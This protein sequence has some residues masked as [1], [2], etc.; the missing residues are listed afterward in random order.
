[1]TYNVT[2]SLGMILFDLALLIHMRFNH[3]SI[4]L[5]HK[6]MRRALVFLV[7]SCLVDVVAGILSTDNG[8]T[9]AD[10]TAML[11]TS[12]VLL[13]THFFAACMVAGYL[14]TFVSHMRMMR[15]AEDTQVFTR[16]QKWLVFLALP[17][18][19]AAVL[20]EICM[21]GAVLTVSCYLSVLTYAFFFLT[22]FPMHDRLRQRLSDLED[23]LVRAQEA[24]AKAAEEDH[25]KNEFLTNM[26]HEIRTP[27]NAIL[28]MDEM[29][30]RTE[31][32]ERVLSYAADIRNAGHS[33]L[34]IINDILDFSR[35]ESGSLE[36]IEAPYHLGYVLDTVRSMMELRA[37]DKGLLLMSEID[38]A[39]PDELTGDAQRLQ[40]V[41]VN[42]LNNA[43]KYTREGRVTLRL[44]A[45]ERTEKNVTLRFDIE[46]TGIGIKE[47]DLP[48]LFQSYERL[49]AE[50]NRGVEGTGLG[51]TITHNLV[52]LMGGE[53]DVKSEYGRGSV[54]SVTL[55]QE[56]TGTQTLA[57]YA[58]T[59]H[60]E[61]AGESRRF[62]APEA[63]V[64]AVDDTQSNLRVVEHLLRQTMI[65]VDT[66]LSG[67]A[68]LS[69]LHSRAYD[70]VLLDHMMPG[71][72]GIETLHKIRATE[73]FDAEKT[74]ILVLTANAIAGARE[75]YLA[76]GFDDYLSKPVESIQLEDA[77]I[78]YLPKEKL[79]TD[80]DARYTDLLAA[81]QQE[82]AMQEL[83]GDTKDAADMEVLRRVTHVDLEEALYL[84]TTPALLR[85][86]MV[87]FA[88]A[89]DEESALIE[90]YCEARDWKNYTIRVHAL[91]SVAR[92]IGAKEL[93][94]DAR[95][96]E[97]LGNAE[98]ETEILE[99]T[100]KLLDDYRAY[101]TYLAPV[102][103]QPED[104]DEKELIPDDELADAYEALREFADA[105]DFDSADYIMETLAG[106]RM[107][108]HEKERF[109]RVRR[110]VRRMDAA[111]LTE[112]L[113]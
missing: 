104:D 94:G 64:L 35:I 16:A 66:C 51:L 20:Y 4:A 27:L 38:D 5:Y 72:D 112:A 83:A 70:V 67:E 54:F 91:K 108:D 106:Y 42:L 15:D 30:L 14:L 80:S 23:A 99:K 24:E 53:I 13:F 60:L 86:T 77:M 59:K 3:R 10:R 96:L 68:A 105:N 81:W 32:E 111:A 21:D 6:R 98:N 89:I 39:L 52:H 43:I 75:M 50:K 107:S 90:A 84:C 31:R 12:L 76:E 9:A 92:L 109:D 95:F 73:G 93:S 46:D 29:I 47:E 7:I 65:H 97:G 74:K 40:Q 102:L 45:T 57:S 55:P 103:K 87:D 41:L 82:Q 19:L 79:V 1:M 78:K 69:M 2:L 49:D 48:R 28:G 34:N 36:T 100:P 22:E 11:V 44:Y 33:L 8:V 58:Q 18:L 71:M 26:S 85:S 61:K 101:R 62:F 88:E 56:I 110:A 63:H 17:G 25:G 113:S 37:A